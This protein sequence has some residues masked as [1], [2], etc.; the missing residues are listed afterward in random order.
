M[1]RDRAQQRIDY[2]FFRAPRGMRVLDAHVIDE[3]T[4]SDHRPVLVTFELE[5]P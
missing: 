2:V 1:A 5:Q 4:I 3:R